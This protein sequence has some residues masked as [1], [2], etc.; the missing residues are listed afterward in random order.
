[1][2]PKRWNEKKKSFFVTSSL[3]EMYQILRGIAILVRRWLIFTNLMKGAK[4]GSCIQFYE[5][6]G[7]V[8]VRQIAKV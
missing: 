3:Q 1:M 5:K 4:I 6:F 2:Y 8:V 7:F